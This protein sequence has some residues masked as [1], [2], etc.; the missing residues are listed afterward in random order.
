MADCPIC[1]SAYALE[2]STMLDCGATVETIASSTGLDVA[3]VQEHIET[4]CTTVTDDDSPDTLEKSDKRLR[5][6]SER[7]TAATLGAGLS[8]DAKSQIA[9]LAIALRAETELRRRLEDQI[10]R[11]H[12]QGGDIPEISIAQFDR[13]IERAEEF[14]RSVG[15]PSMLIL[16]V[17]SHVSMVLHHYQTPEALDL[18]SKFLSCSKPDAKLSQDFAAFVAKRTGTQT[19]DPDPAQQLVWSQSVPAVYGGN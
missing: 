16:N 10:E 12:A 13:I 19:P 8:G 3:L 15:S 5:V 11:Q 1:T 9:A 18:M 4:C 17:C 2:I 14:H 7:I 6:L